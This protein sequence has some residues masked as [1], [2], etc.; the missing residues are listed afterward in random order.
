MS[1]ETSAA[2]ADDEQMPHLEDA[3]SPGDKH[4]I[5]EGQGAEE[6]IRGEWQRAGEMQQQSDHL[7]DV[8]DEAR[9]A[10]AKASD[11][12]SMESGG[13]GVRPEDVQDQGSGKAEESGGASERAQERAEE[14]DEAQARS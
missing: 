14:D 3:A 8:L 4:S 5:V 10:V 12:D 1:E 11:A 7:R 2:T 6:E 13:L 9:E